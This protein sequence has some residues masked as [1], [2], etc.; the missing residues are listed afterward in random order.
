MSI[1]VHKE[2]SGR[3]YLVFQGRKVPLDFSRSHSGDLHVEAVALR[4]GL[5]LGIDI[6]KVRDIP[7]SE[8][9]DLV[10]HNFSQREWQTFKQ[11]ADEQK[12]FTFFRAWTQ[13]EAL[14]KACRF[15]LQA[16][17][18]F[19]VEID[20]MSPPCLQESQI[21]I[22]DCQFF[23]INVGPGY[24]CMLAVVGRSDGEE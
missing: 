1:E 16:F 4:P 9:S 8:I 20:L 23:E 19:S 3:P 14:V 7:L 12:R 2:P 11:L 13:K 24:I 15:N 18:Y 17:K 10:E 21:E 5:R 22:G 6:E